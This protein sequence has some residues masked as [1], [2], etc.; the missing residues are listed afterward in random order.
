MLLYLVTQNNLLVI[1]SVFSDTTSVCESIDNIDNIDYNE[2]S[3]EDKL[4]VDEYKK[5]IEKDKYV[6]YKRLPK[7][8]QQDKQKLHYYNK[9]IVIYST[10]HTPGSK[11]RDPVYG[12]FSSARVGSKD[13]YNYF[14]IRMADF[15]TDDRTPLT[16]FYDSPEGYEKHQHT[17]VSADIKNKWHDKHRNYVGYNAPRFE[18]K[19]DTF[20]K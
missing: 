13:E 2:L 15:A 8:D 9:K 5:F 14:K 11:I 10:R 16:L 1:M 3:D 4:N 17:R 6:I 19:G 12:T 7:K 18:S 20:I